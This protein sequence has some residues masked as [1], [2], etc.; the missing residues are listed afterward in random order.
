M[1][2]G[3]GNKKPLVWVT[4]GKI[5]HRAS[6]RPSRRKAVAVK[7]A[8][9]Q[10]APTSLASRPAKVARAAVETSTVPVTQTNPIEHIAGPIR[11]GCSDVSPIPGLETVYCAPGNGEPRKNAWNKSPTDDGTAVARWKPIRRASTPEPSFQQDHFQQ[12]FNAIPASLWVE[13]YEL[14]DAVDFYIHRQYLPR[15][16]GQIVQSIYFSS[17]ITASEIIP[18]LLN[19]CRRHCFMA[20]VIAQQLFFTSKAHGLGTQYTARAWAKF[21]HYHGRAIQALNTELSSNKCLLST[22]TLTNV[23]ILMAAEAF[24]DPSVGVQVHIRGFLALIDLLGGLQKI[25]SMQ[26]TQISTLQGF[27]V[28]CVFSSTSSP[29]KDPIVRVSQMDIDDLHKLYTCSAIPD[30]LCPSQ[31]FLDIVRINRL[32]FEAANKPSIMAP[33]NL[34]QDSLRD[35]LRDIWSFTPEHWAQTCGYPHPD[36][37]LLIARTFQYSVALYAIV[38]LSDAFCSFDDLSQS[39]GDGFPSGQQSRKLLF[40]NIGL[41]MDSGCVETMAWP[42]AVAGVVAKTTSERAAVEA[43]IDKFVDY[44][45]FI[46]AMQSIKT[47]LQRYWASGKT[48]WDNC[49]DRSHFFA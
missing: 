16:R 36:K 26:N 37:S 27:F 8:S 41:S 28:T 35:I 33:G 11:F 44:I 31:L 6:Q 15:A 43:S 30:A 17:N 5:T 24:R 48:G 9:K 32:R 47:T 38:S 10:R 42:L 14:F 45:G 29:P 46:T 25:V 4:P 7:D 34:G 21:Y 12:K 1:C 23:W 19:P 2:P 49:F 39:D 40:K 18:A 13:D 22:Q 20:S 3:F